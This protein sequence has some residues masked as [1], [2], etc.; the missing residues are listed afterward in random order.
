MNVIIDKLNIINPIDLDLYN[1]SLDVDDSTNI[2]YLYSSIRLTDGNKIEEL[3]D[4]FKKYV[5][6]QLEIIFVDV[7]LLVNE[8]KKEKLTLFLTTVKTRIDMYKSLYKFLQLQ[9][10]ISIYNRLLD[11][12]FNTLCEHNVMKSFIRVIGDLKTTILQQCNNV[13]YH[14]QIINKLFE[15]GIFSIE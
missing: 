8:E 12:V 11:I 15:M 2:L 4:I 9:G 13:R 1:Q 14:T 10:D 7:E 6:Q 5:N 3:D